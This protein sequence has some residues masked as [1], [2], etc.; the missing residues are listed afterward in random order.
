M[1]VM[2]RDAEVDRTAAWAN[3]RSTVGH[4]L[5]RSIP[6]PPPSGSARMALRA[7]S[8]RQTMPESI[9]PSEVL[10]R[11]SLLTRRRASGAYR[12]PRGSRAA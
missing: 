2:I 9:K 8:R 4:M 7:R 12:S 3:G 6:Q 10:V 1:T 5:C 11:A